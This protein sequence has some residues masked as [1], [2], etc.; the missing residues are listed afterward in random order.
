MAIRK[1]P[2]LLPFLLI[3]TA[4]V[5][6]QMVAPAADDSFP[7]SYNPPGGTDKVFVFNRPQYKAARTAAVTA[8]S[9]DKTT[10]WNFQ[11]AR[12]DPVAR[13]FTNLSGSAS[14]WQSTLDTLTTAG[15]YQATVTKGASTYVFRTWVLFNDFEV[16]ITNKDAYDSLLFGYYNCASL[17]LRADTNQVRL[18]YYNPGTQEKVWVYNSLTIRWTTDNPEASNPSSRLITRVNNP[19][20]ED[21]W[22]FLSVTDRFNLVRTDSVFYKSIQSAAKMSA[23]YVSLSDTIAYPG[24]HYER[25]YADDNHSA[26]GIYRFDFSASKNAALYQLDFGDGENME[27]S[28]GDSI[29][30]HE[31]E[32]P[33]KYKVV[34]TTKSG[35]PYECADSVTA[36]AE[37]VYGKL[38]LPNVF[39]PNSDGNNDQLIFDDNNL[40]R[41]EDLSVVSIDIAI[42]DRAGQKMHVYSGNMRDWKGWDGKVMRSNRDAPEGVYYYVITALFYYRDPENPISNNVF[43]GFFHLYRR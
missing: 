30:A 8:V 26:P 1:I 24:K 9:P 11:W 10:G 39:S 32:K 5:S 25:F 17:D 14:G 27:T 6:A 34:L 13:V 22:Y 38:A 21:T 41:S 42:F 19:P 43:K 40:F 4:R 35:K 20:S 16:V 2:I 18:F 12:F 23:T 7:A 36:E 31:F 33:G 29:V 28:Q 15:G 37:L 3:L